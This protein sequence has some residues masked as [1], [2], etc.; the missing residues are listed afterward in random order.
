[1]LFICL[2]RFDWDLV[3][4]VKSL[5]LFLG[6]LLGQ[7]R[8]GG[9]RRRWRGWRRSRRRP[10]VG[11]TTYREWCDSPLPALHS[12]S[13]S[14][15]LQTLKITEWIKSGQDKTNNFLKMTI[16][17]IL[18]PCKDQM[19]EIWR[20]IRRKVET[21]WWICGIWR[22]GWNNIIIL[23]IWFSCGVNLLKKH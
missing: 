22:H 2:S 21:E 4:K 5:D 3:L 7:R 10:A 19:L 12:P 8:R 1:M 20:R 9:S 14:Y 13:H 17:L 11:P 18:W 15:V 23:P 6:R 16:Y